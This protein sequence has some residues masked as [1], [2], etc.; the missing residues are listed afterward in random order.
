[1]ASYVLYG[2]DTAGTLAEETN[3][4]RRRAPWAILRALSAAGIAGGLLIVAAL[5]AV[6]DPANPELGQIGGGLPYIVK[7][8]LGELLGSLFL[9]IVV[10]AV[11]V[12]A[13]AVHAS[14]VRL[15]FAM[16]RD[17]NLPFARPLARVQ[18]GTRTPVV[19]ALATGVIAAFLLL[20]N[21]NH[22]RIME[23]LCSL[24]I[25]WANLAY[26]LVTLPLL[27]KRL[28]GWPTTLEKHV[29]P[30]AGADRAQDQ[31]FSLGQWGLA[32]NLASVAWG[33]FVVVNMCWPRA[34]IY[35][36]DSWGRFA[37]VIATAALVCIG[38]LYHRFVRRSRGGILE[39]HAAS[40][41]NDGDTVDCANLASSG[42][43]FT[44]LVPG[45]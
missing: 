37:G 42:G 7:D 25:V 23:T 32:I 19:P 28:R 33:F 40:G 30:F 34:E 43:L 24:A 45:D 26:L 6:R 18:H 14:A 27:I 12:C 4:P 35:G 31:L 36:T 3:Q 29:Q 13:L 38:L 8:I 5:M 9:C 1:M 16:A 41:R 17:N 22:T 11:A 15:T 21:I 44:R 39:E 10:F 20:L 2:F